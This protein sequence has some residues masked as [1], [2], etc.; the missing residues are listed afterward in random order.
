MFLRDD[1]HDKFCSQAPKP[2]RGRVK[3]YT[4]LRTGRRSDHACYRRYAGSKVRKWTCVCGELAHIL[5]VV[6]RAFL[7]GSPPTMMKRLLPISSAHENY[8]GTS[9]KALMRRS[10]STNMHFL[11]SQSSP[12]AV[13]KSSANVCSRMYAILTPTFYHIHPSCTCQIKFS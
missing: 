8:Q 1:G 12:I 5:I 2:K 9:S 11:H 7:L 13:P 6:A 3:P 10:R 4:H